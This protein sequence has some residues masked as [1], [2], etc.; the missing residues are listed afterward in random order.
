M[1]MF[2]SDGYGKHSYYFAVKIHLIILSQL[3]DSI[4]FAANRP[5]LVTDL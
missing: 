1:Q 5:F 2:L 4:H 3:F